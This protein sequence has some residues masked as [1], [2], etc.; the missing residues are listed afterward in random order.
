MSHFR[1]YVPH[2]MHVK[3][4]RGGITI[5][6]RF[7][8]PHVITTHKTFYAVFVSD[9]RE[10]EDIEAVLCWVVIC[11]PAITESLEYLYF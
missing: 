1:G 11:L 2:V 4:G 9:G 7:C 10:L 3:F 5:P 8:V 6:C